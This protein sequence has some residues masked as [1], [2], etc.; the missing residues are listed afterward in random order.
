MRESRVKKRWSQGKPV[1]ATVAHFTDPASAELIGLMGFDCLWIDLE[2]QPVG[3]AEAANMMRAARVGDM[4]VMARP[5]KGE[6]MRMARLLEAGASL[7]MYPRCESAA[8]ARELVRCAKFPPLGE[9]GFFTAS[10]DN[11]YSTMPP[12][13]YLRQANDQTIL[14]AQIESPTA[15]KHASEIAA[16]EGIDMLF[17]GPGDFSMMSGVAG[18][19]GLPLVQDALRETCRASLAAGKRFGTIVSGVDYTRSMLEI[20]ATL[21]CYGGDLHFVRQALVDVRK[22]FGPLGFE[23]E[24]KLRHDRG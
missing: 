16:V 8:E 5:A 19:F 23:F 14:I 24:P 2:H 1:L 7:I 13:D 12:K 6:F 10:P 22:Q 15:V 20:G 18:E 17:F 11:P 21:L 4:D 3:M 9:R